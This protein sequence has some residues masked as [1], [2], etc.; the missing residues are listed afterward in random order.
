MILIATI[1]W[2]I[3]P[4][5][6]KL[7]YSNATF[8]Q[9][10]GIRAIP[11]V[12]IAFFYILITNKASFKIT[13]KEFSALFYLALFGSI[14]GDLIYFYSIGKISVVNY[15]V[16]GHLQPIFVLLIGYFF[17]KTDKITKYDYIGILFMFFA[18]FFVVAKD[19]DSLK[20]FSIGT[21]EDYFL[22]IATISWSTTAIMARKYLSNTNA[23]I[24][25]FYRFGI[26]AVIL[27]TYLIC[28]NAFY[29]SNF[30]QILDGILAGF[31]IILYY[32]SMKRLKAAQVTSLELTS[33]FFAAVFGLIF[34]GEFVTIMQMAGMAL[35]IFG[36]YF[37]SKKE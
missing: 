6:I 19:M 17:L 20:S 11:M 21:K 12:I 10:L 28:T 30:Y 25:T 23:G 33:P 32:E 27:I 36:I 4:V 29:V 22:L 1:V 2:A 3:D 5:V 14:I 8:V 26:G 35:L 34:L 13:K 9:T 7:S 24:T 18:A 16:I 15:S 31:A 37:L